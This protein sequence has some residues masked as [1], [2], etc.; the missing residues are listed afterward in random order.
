VKIRQGKTLEVAVTT[1]NTRTTMAR[2]KLKRNPREE[3]IS[4]AN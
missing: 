4:Q 2:K 1:T 3:K